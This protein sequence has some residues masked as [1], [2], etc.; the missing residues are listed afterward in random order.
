MGPMTASY[1]MRSEAPAKFLGGTVNGGE[2]EIIVFTKPLPQDLELAKE[3]KRDGIKIAVDI[4][5]DHFRHQ[6][7]GG[8]YAEM[9]KLA[10]LVITPTTNMSDR[11]VKYGLRQ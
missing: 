1:R 9:V 6:L 2:G 8:S 7:V 10:D 4:I 5:D 3:C 11:L